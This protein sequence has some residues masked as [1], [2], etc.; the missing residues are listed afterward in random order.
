MMNYWL[1]RL[2]PI[3]NTKTELNYHKPVTFICADRCGTECIS[4][5]EGEG[6]TTFMGTSCIIRINP[7]HLITYLKKSEEG[8]ILGEIKL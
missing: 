2:K 4:E 6:V 3:T 5:S 7:V 8:Y 1:S